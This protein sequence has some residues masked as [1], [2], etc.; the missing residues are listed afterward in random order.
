MHKE[1]LEKIRIKLFLHLL[2]SVSIIVAGII[3]M[4]F[5]EDKILC[6]CLSVIG[7]FLL[8]ITFS[9]Y[10]GK[11]EENTYVIEAECE[12]RSRSGYRK[13]YFEYLFKSDDGRSFEIKTTQKEKFKVGLKYRMCFKKSKNKENE[14]II[15]GTDLI[16]SEIK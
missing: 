15:Y 5:L 11:N 3:L 14:Q 6:G 8:Y 1:M 4:I 10:G 12:N 2:G 13:Q 9:K 16:F 7:I